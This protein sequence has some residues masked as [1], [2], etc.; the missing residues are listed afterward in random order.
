MY[1]RMTVANMAA[2]YRE[3]LLGEWTLRACITKGKTSFFLTFFNLYEVT[4]VNQ[5]FI[6]VIISWYISQIIKVYTLNLYMLYDLNKI[7]EKCKHLE[8]TPVLPT[9]NQNS[10][11][12][13]REAAILS[14]FKIYLTGH[15]DKIFINVFLSIKWNI[16]H[17]QNLYLHNYQ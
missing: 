14:F 11:H 8:V 17:F 16:F 1:N 4:E 7:G 3:K 9:L 13:V 10:G 5:T 6:V 12:G 15:L 2:W